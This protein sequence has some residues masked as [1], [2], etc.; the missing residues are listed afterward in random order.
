MLTL[1]PLSP[2]SPAL[3]LRDTSDETADAWLHVEALSGATENDVEV[4]SP[5]MDSCREPWPGTESSL[6]KRTTEN[7]CRGQLAELLLYAVTVDGGKH[8]CD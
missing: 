8:M 4:R 3:Q 2:L 5:A 1:S 6:A 7:H